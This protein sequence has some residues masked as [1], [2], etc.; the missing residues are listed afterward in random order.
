MYDDAFKVFDFNISVIFTEQ[1][2]CISKFKIFVTI[3]DKQV[4]LESF[5]IMQKNIFIYSV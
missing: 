5:E 3:F 1:I 4:F 2:L